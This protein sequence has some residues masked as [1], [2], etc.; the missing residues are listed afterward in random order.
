VQYSF[1]PP[2]PLLLRAMS[3]TYT[4]LVNGAIAHALGISKADIRRSFSILPNSSCHER[5]GSRAAQS[6]TLNWKQFAIFR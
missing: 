1:D 5:A 4:Q 6:A 2:T 3:S